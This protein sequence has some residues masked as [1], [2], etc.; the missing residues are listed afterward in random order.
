MN[1]SEGEA[2]LLSTEYDKLHATAKATH[3]ALVELI[4]ILMAKKADTFLVHRLQTIAH[5]LFVELR[6]D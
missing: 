3:R 2:I 1:L 6:R 5:N 4:S